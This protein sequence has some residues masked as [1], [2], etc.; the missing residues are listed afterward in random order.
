MDSFL[1]QSKIK[2]YIKEKT[3]LNTSAAFFEPLNKD[4]RESVEQ[5]VARAQK[6]GRKT[7]MGKDFSFYLENTDVEESLVVAS[8]IK[9]YVKESAQM[10][11]SSQSF[12]QLSARIQKI[13]E[14]SANK[15]LTDKRRTLLERDFTPPTVS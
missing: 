8:K 3:G 14:A 4:I 5:A 1:V 9:R 12:D 7:V 6:A 13:C 11:T 15:A 10:A 2:R